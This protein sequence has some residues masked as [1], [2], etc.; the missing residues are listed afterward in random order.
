MS[1]DEQSPVSQGSQVS[2]QS[3]ASQRSQMSRPKAD[4]SDAQLL[5]VRQAVL[6]A[7]AGLA[8]MASMAP[9][10]ALAWVLGAFELS[11]VAGLS[12]IVALGPSFLYGTIIFVG[13][14]M[15]TLPLLFVSL[16][17]FLPG[18]AVIVKVPSSVPSSGRGS[19]SPSGRGRPALRWRCSSSSRWWPTSPTAPSSAPS[20]PATRASRCT[21]CEVTGAGDAPELTSRRA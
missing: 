1:N 19:P 20:T 6:G 5:G 13:G 8:G 16:A 17:L 7:A 3:Q 2:Q 4:A 11:A 14:G 18:D 12:D 10:L 15:T 9:F 21:T